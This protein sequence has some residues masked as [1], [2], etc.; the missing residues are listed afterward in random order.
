MKRQYLTAGGVLV[1]ADD[2]NLV[3]CW[4]RGRSLRWK[5]PCYRVVMGGF[6]GLLWA[7][8]LHEVRP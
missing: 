5:L 2:R 8:R 7:H 6:H 1:E 4:W 3:E